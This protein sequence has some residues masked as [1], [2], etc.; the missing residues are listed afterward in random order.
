MIK[1]QAVTE[2]VVVGCHFSCGV[3]YGL[4]SHTCQ[5]QIKVNRGLASKETV[6]PA[7]VGK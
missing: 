3:I 6:V 4:N 1:P 5:C 2:I 7:L